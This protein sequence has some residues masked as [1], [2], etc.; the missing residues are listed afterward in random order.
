[1]FI[2]MQTEERQ[3][4]PQQAEASASS[5]TVRAP[6]IISESEDDNELAAGNFE[7]DEFERLV[8]RRQEKKASLSKS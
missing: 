2:R 8:S 1:M 3:R 5:R 4:A 7:Q 6:S